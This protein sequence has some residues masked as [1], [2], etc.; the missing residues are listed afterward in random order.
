MSR[1]TVHKAWNCPNLSTGYA[2]YVG[3]MNVQQNKM[4]IHGYYLT[5]TLEILKKGAKRK[6]ISPSFQQITSNTSSKTL[7]PLLTQKHITD[8]RYKPMVKTYLLTPIV[9][10]WFIYTAQ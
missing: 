9:T 7:K 3:F 4:D 2:R 8:V 10:I 5:N 1:Y 6:I